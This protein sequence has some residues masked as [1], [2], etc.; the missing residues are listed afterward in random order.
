MV[1]FTRRPGKV[2]ASSNVHRGSPY[3]LFFVFSLSIIPRRI[4]A[5]APALPIVPWKI[6]GSAELYE[7]LTGPDDDA[8][9]ASIH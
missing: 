4:L 6:P 5:Q 3:F 7:Y 9:I 8:L 2:G 1:S